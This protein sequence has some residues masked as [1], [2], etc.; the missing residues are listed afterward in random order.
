MDG[1]ELVQ[2][3]Q[4]HHPEIPTIIL[5][6]VGENGISHKTLRSKVD[7]YLEKAITPKELLE[8][9]RRLEK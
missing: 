3:I 9:I 5:T 1:W 8:T 6:G 2:W 4:G 7:L